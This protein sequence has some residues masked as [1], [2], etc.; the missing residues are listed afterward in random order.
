M[1][2]TAAG[3]ARANICG[4][5]AALCGESSDSK[6]IVN[7]LSDWAKLIDDDF[8]RGMSGDAAVR[9]AAD[10]I[11]DESR[12]QDGKIVRLEFKRGLPCLLETMACD[13]AARSC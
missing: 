8:G 3:S 11:T 13:D 6:T 4:L 1:A 2:C 12:L 5:N 9:D 10:K 7:H